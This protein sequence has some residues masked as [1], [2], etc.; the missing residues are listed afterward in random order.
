MSDRSRS[1]PKSR[2]GRMAAFGQLAA[3]VAAGVVGEGLG[4]LAKGER[5]HLS[6]LLMTPGNA[7]RV[8][9]QLSRLR[10]AA[11]KLG[12]MLSLDAGDLLPAEL[13]TILSQL[14]ET[15]HV[16]PQSQLQQCLVAA[17]GPDWRQH[18][19]RFDMAPI[20]AASIGQVH[21]ATLSS[22]REIAVKVQ[23]P[24]ISASI[25][26]DIDNVATLLRMSG[27]LPHGLSISAHLTEA[28]RQ[29]HEEADYLR[30]AEQ[31][32][33][34]RTLLHDDPRFVVPEPVTALLRP[35]VL[36][37]DFI[38]GT[39]IETL[40]TEAEPQRNAAMSALIELALKELFT[41]G[42]MQTDPNFGNYRWQSEAKRIVLLDFGAT[43]A[44]SPQ[45]AASYQELLSAALTDDVP[46]VRAALI[47]TRFLSA[48]QVARHSD[49]IDA[50]IRLLLAR[51]HQ[52][53]DGLFDF[54]DRR[55][56]KVLRDQS[57]AMVADRQSWH[58]PPPE[59]MFIQ[60]KIS[61][62]ALL[63]SNM[64]AKLPLLDML[65]RVG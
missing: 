34:Y 54:A 3:G 18:F 17:W 46:T 60:R 65:V 28:K 64:R 45:T 53:P 10:G 52:A 4:R 37:M 2:F 30:E 39:P 31:M 62:M 59:T 6:D 58:L 16:M 55:F 15:A 43:R 48:T 40:T 8:T 47:G 21:R 56:V 32:T 19:S 14:R 29:L 27:L 5:P 35:T 25:D 41:F 61:G 44:V 49:D 12:Q 22:G 1:V 23:Y 20:A 57:T 9:E 11:M 24:G 7:R 36:P 42:L 26:A 50:M 63:A 38:A 33:L 51:L 13:T